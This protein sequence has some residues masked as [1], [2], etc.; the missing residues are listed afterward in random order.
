MLEI[1]E[2]VLAG[3]PAHTAAALA[4]LAALGVPL[5]IDD[6]GTGYSSLARLRRLPVSEIKIDAS[7]ITRLLGDPDNELIVKSLVELV[8]ALGLKSVAE[9]VESPD[10]AGALAT[11]GCDAAQGRY[12]CGPLDPAATT[13]WLADHLRPAATSRPR[14]GRAHPPRSRQPGGRRRPS[15][16]PPTGAIDR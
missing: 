6:F 10:V 8:R 12:Y 14:H 9:G 2:A 4:A 15:P 3:G 13:A 16:V 11:M 5:S 1:N 7:F